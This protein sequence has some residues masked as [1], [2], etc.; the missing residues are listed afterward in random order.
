MSRSRGSNMTSFED[1]TLCQAFIQVIVDY[2]NGANQT[3][4]RLW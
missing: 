2:I 4:V 3:T 1:E